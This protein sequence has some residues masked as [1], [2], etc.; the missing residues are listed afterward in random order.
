MGPGPAAKILSVDRPFALR[1][2]DALPRIDIAYETWGTLDPRRGNAVLLFTGL[3]PSAHAAS[4][5]AD[6]S[7][8]WWEDMVGPGKP[9][10]TQRLFVICVNSLG[11]CFGSTGPASDD[12][13]TGERYG[14]RFPVLTI[15]D[16]AAAGREVI[17]ALGIERV[18]AVAGAS[19]G[20]MTA[21][22]YALLHPGQ[23]RALVQISCAVHSLPFAIALR[24]LQ[25]EMIRSDPDWR[26]GNYDPGAGPIRGMRLARKL[27]MITYRSAREWRE[28]FGRERVGQPGSEPFGVTFEIESYLEAHAQKFIGG[29]DANCYL[30]LSRA[31]D[32]FDAAAHGGGSLEKAFA[33]ID[34]ER[35]LVIGVDTDFLFTVDQQQ[36]LARLLEAPGR[37]TEFHALPS[38]QGH[39]SFLVDMARFRPVVGAFLW[40]LP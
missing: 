31:M 3:S 1:S 33:R 12:P 18:A 7:P 9:F 4:S 32:L 40:K 15:E 39:D 22:A 21:L 26:G 38:I 10:D 28:R 16:I 8:G 24:S 29:Y 25:R 35:A 23:V 2:G 30:Y 6:P 5:P 17:A 14:L 20:G 37:Q 11:S 34:V 13:R 27:G 36:E 19:M